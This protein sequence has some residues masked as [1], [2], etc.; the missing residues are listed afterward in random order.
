MTTKNKK[1]KS[2]KS[3]KSN[4]HKKL[5]KH[6][7]HKNRA[8]N[9]IGVVI[10]K[11]VNSSQL[12]FVPTNE[13]LKHKLEMIAYNTEREHRHDDTNVHVEKT[14]KIQQARIDHA[15]VLNTLR[16]KINEWMLGGCEYVK[17][18]K[19]NTVDSSYREGVIDEVVF[20]IL[21]NDMREAG[22]AL[23]VSESMFNY[24]LEWEII[25]S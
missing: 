4:K 12:S 16:D 18:S 14:S 8:D 23:E 20:D 17:F 21:K 24:Y 3:S 15:V 22:Y 11:E 19:G 9:E 25:V 10:N 5:K 13:Y 1:D 7:R 2:S 6:K